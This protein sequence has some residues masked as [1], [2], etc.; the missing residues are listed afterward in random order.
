MTKRTQLGEQ[1]YPST[2]AYPRQRHE[3]DDINYNEQVLTTEFLVTN[4]TPQ[5]RIFNAVTDRD[6]LDRRFRT[7]Q[8]PAMNIERLNRV[9]NCKVI[10]RDKARVLESAIMADYMSAMREISFR[11][12]E[13]P[14]PLFD[15]EL[16]P[17]PAAYLLRVS[18]N[19]EMQT[20]STTIKVLSKYGL[21][22]YGR[23][24]YPNLFRIQKAFSML[25]NT[26]IGMDGF[27]HPS[28]LTTVA[29]KNLCMRH[30]S[31]K[32]IISQI[33]ILFIESICSPY[34]PV[35]VSLQVMQFRFNLSNSHV[36]NLVRSKLLHDIETN[37]GH[38]SSKLIYGGDPEQNR[39]RKRHQKIV[40]NMIG[41]LPSIK[42]VQ[43]KFRNVRAKL[44]LSKRLDKEFVAQIFGL[45][46]MPNLNVQ[47]EIPEAMTNALN[48]LAQSI[49]SGTD[50]YK[51]GTKVNFGLS[52]PAL[53]NIF[54]NETFCGNKEFLYLSLLLAICSIMVNSKSLLLE[55]VFFLAVMYG[56]Y[57]FMSNQRV[58]M[59]VAAIYSLYLFYK[60]NYVDSSL[61]DIEIEKV[62]KSQ[63]ADLPADSIVDM[64]MIYLYTTTMSASWEKGGNVLKE[65][66]KETGSMK[67]S[68]EGVKFTFDYFLAFANKFISWFCAKM[69]IDDFSYRQSTPFPLLDTLSLEIPA[70]LRAFRDK[71]E[72]FNWESSQK[73]YDLDTQ[74]DKLIAMI[75]TNKE[76]ITYKQGAMWLKASLKPLV[77]R[78]QSSNVINNGPRKS[79]FGLLLGGGTQVGKTVV[80][81]PLITDILVRVLSDEKLEVFKK[82]QADFICYMNKTDEYCSNYHGQ[83]A[84]VCDEFLQR[85]DSAGVENFELMFAFDAIGNKNFNISGASI[86]EKAAKNFTS[87]LYAATTN[88][89]SFK[90]LHSII[91]REALA[92]RFIAQ[93][94]QTVKEE[95][96]TEETKDLGIGARRIDVNK[97]NAAPRKYATD[98]FSMDVY[99]FYEYN[100]DAKDHGSMFK[101]LVP[102]SY[103]QL[104]EKLALEFLKHD[105][106]EDDLIN[107]VTNMHKTSLLER[108]NFRK[109]ASANGFIKQIGESPE[110]R[111]NGVSD[112]NIYFASLLYAELKLKKLGYDAKAYFE[113]S[114]WRTTWDCAKMSLYTFFEENIA[115]Y[116]DTV[117]EPI[118]SESYS[119]SSR[120]KELLSKKS[121]WLGIGAVLIGVG[122]VWNLYKDKYIPQSDYPMKVKKGDKTKARS[123]AKTFSK[124]SKKQGAVLPKNHL[125]II[126]KIYRKNLVCFTVPGHT[127]P[128]GGHMLF[129]KSRMAVSPHHFFR[130]FESYSE[131]EK[132]K[133]NKL[134]I[135]FW[136]VA[137][138]DAVT[139]MYYDELES[140][141]P[142]EKQNEDNDVEGD[143]VYWLFPANTFERTDITGL[144]PH[145]DDPFLLTKFHGN[146]LSTDK[147][148]YALLPS[149]V[150]PISNFTYEDVTC[151]IGY[152]YNIATKVG[153]CGKPLFVTDSRSTVP[154]LVGFHTAGNGSTGFATTLDIEEVN[155]ASDY[156][157]DLLGKPL[158]SYEDVDSETVDIVADTKSIVEAFKKEGCL[159]ANLIPEAMEVSG[160]TMPTTTKV[161][162][163][164][165]YDTY[166]PPTCKPAYLKP[167]VKDGVI[168]DPLQL[169]RAKLCPPR[170]AV[171]MK[172]LK[173]VTNIYIRK[174]ITNSVM[175]S[176]DPPRVLTMKEAIEGIPGKLKG[177]PR[178]TSAGFPWSFFVKNGKTWFWGNDGAYEYESPSWK[179]LESTLRLKLLLLKQRKRPLF[180][181]M[182]FLKDERR[183][184]DKAN[185]GKTR[186]F[187]AG[188]VDYSILHRMYFGHGMMYMESNRITNG[189]AIGVNPYS[190]EWDL[191]AK[192]LLSAGNNIMALDAANFDGSIPICVQYATLEWYHAY[193]YN[194]TPEEREIRTIL[195][196]EMVNSKHVGVFNINMTLD[197]IESPAP[198]T[199]M[200]GCAE[201]IEAIVR[202]QTEDLAYSY[203]GSNVSGIPGTA[204]HNT[205]CCHICY[206]YGE[207]AV[208]T[209]AEHYEYSK[210]KEIEPIKRIVQ[211]GFG[212]D[213]TISVPNDLKVIDQ[214]TLTETMKLIGLT[215]TPEDKSDTKHK[216]RSLFEVTFLKRY[217][218]KH[219][220]THLIIGKL[221][222]DVILEMPQ[223]TKKGAPKGSVESTCEQ[224][225]TELSAHPRAVF[226]KWFPLISAQQMERLGSL[227]VYSTYEEYFARFQS[228]QLEY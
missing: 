182:T 23:L 31:C 89:V 159:P 219:E 41:E 205:H 185:Q 40:K 86:E 129:L 66:V 67:K 62:W 32:R 137:A 114:N 134:V 4:R 106:H 132:A 173:S 158:I 220:L 74:C 203:T 118:I 49:N 177:L 10:V 161:R 206:N 13:A 228:L 157:S 217:F 172:L 160:L 133:G 144:L 191:M 77:T 147:G 58:V 9:H 95:Y 39:N 202:F 212:D 36:F 224:A 135:K 45:P 213:I 59:I 29:N 145:P 178:K 76:F 100:F 110:W 47:V 103:D 207:A 210:I 181:F 190:S 105:G 142:E 7:L 167:F 63:I 189:S 117:V 3:I 56:Q 71:T 18:N 176:T 124:K 116:R 60:S 179:A 102:M 27:I 150:I 52:M 101:S 120:I 186:L 183:P 156:F 152:K 53:D 171:N 111:P 166:H 125:D 20:W 122:F 65:F 204:H 194:A 93:I 141:V 139:S 108:E 222:L 50:A 42:H 208:L 227:P 148:G 61:N 54:N 151:N 85:V 79:P 84:F 221:V 72:E 17:G 199:D 1:S 70:I 119:L 81:N 164:P 46:S 30:L 104:V 12:L 87:H 51:T 131:I 200:K 175:D 187:N 155:G 109:K 68:F 127:A 180:Y 162:K 55:G 223:W 115:T 168:I 107:F 24:M 48:E 35:E 211:E 22:D 19:F 69:D 33:V 88:R 96:A 43:K 6:A 154:M 75:P 5:P 82:N 188:S 2:R 98:K 78:L 121:V 94:W 16:F 113:W 201:S 11:P 34:F 128:I 80:L 15:L 146:L 214:T 26:L 184:I 225:Y 140:V 218:A 169:A 216:H 37:P 25:S 38:S 28:I 215:C 57:H 73:V 8:S 198:L 197:L 14:T 92:R 21:E 112:E 170:P 130:C 195:W 149:E 174:S 143:R 196:E 123:A 193:Y 209:N 44:A 165:L 138:P 153:D 91:A 83:Y 163:S 64:I 226:N 192:N 136:S 90:D 97:A 99:E 126:S